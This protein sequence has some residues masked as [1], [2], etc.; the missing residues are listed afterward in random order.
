MEN[1]TQN[2]MEL[3]FK[4]LAELAPERQSDGCISWVV[5]PVG[6]ERLQ[7]IRYLDSSQVLCAFAQNYLLNPK[8]LAPTWRFM[9][10]SSYL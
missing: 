9:G 6:Q 10:L 3:D 2:D 8:P 1:P 5:P 7:S 4:G